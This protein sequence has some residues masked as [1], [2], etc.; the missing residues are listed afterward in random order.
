MSLP[1]TLLITLLFLGVLCGLLDVL[2]PSLLLLLLFGLIL[3]LGLLSLL[4]IVLILL[5]SMLLWLLLFRL[6]HLS[7]H[8]FTLLGDSRG[9]GALSLASSLAKSGFSGNSATSSVSCLRAT[10]GCF[11]RRAASASRIF[12]NGRR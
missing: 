4:L 3:L 10:S 12:A 6:E 9:G 8:G 11:S 2:L 7:A 5:L 1:C